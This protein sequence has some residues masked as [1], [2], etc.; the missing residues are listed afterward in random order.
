MH[1]SKSAM[2]LYSL[3]SMKF[4]FQFDQEAFPCA[5]MFDF[6]WIWFLIE[7]GMYTKSVDRE[8]ERSFVYI[9]ID[10]KGRRKCLSISYVHYPPF[11]S[12]IYTILHTADERSRKFSFRVFHRWNIKTRWSMRDL[13]RLKSEDLETNCTKIHNPKNLNSDHHLTLRLHSCWWNII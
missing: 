7:F 3:N 11:H 9:R 8:M 5:S 1:T 4:T 6:Q 13:W 2:K 10:D 12:K